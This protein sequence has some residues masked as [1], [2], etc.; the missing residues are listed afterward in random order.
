MLKE[1]ADAGGEGSSAGFILPKFNMCRDGFLA[2]AIISS[3]NTKTI[4]ECMKL[5][6]QYSQI[7]TKMPLPSYMHGGVI[8]KLS[9]ILKRESSNIV[10][11]DGIKAIIDDDSWVLV[12][13]SNTEHA[14]RVS[15]ESK[16]SLIRTLYNRIINKVQSVYETVK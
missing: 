15:V 16:V 10:T 4:D 3:L 13:A 12:R 1:D 8:E 2:S 6:G 5:S 7:R 9:D 11:I 14:I